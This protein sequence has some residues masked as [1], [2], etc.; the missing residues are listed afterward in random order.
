M[1]RRQTECPIQSFLIQVAT[2]LASQL[3]GKTT[4]IQIADSYRLFEATSLRINAT[5]ALHQA[6]RLECVGSVRQKTRTQQHT[7]PAEPTRDRS[8][9]CR[10]IALGLRFVTLGGGAAV[11]SGADE[12]SILIAVNTV[13]VHV[14]MKTLSRAAVEPTALHRVHRS[15]RSCL[16]GSLHPI[17]K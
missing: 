15:P 4:N 9:R 11:S 13:P 5:I 16:V 3:K 6:Q 1:E 7:S 2:M 17:R 12:R 8:L 10:I 14:S